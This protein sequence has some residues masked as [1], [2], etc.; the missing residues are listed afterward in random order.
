MDGNGSEKWNAQDMRSEI[1]ALREQVRCQEGRIAALEAELT[2]MR[3]A[4][5]GPGMAPQPAW[6]QV[7][8]GAPQMQPGPQ[9]AW[10]QT[11]PM[12]MP[13]QPFPLAPGMQP[14]WQQPP[15]RK[16]KLSE[17]AVGKYGV[18]VLAS[19]LILLGV[20]TGVQIFWAVIP[21]FVKMLLLVW[22]GA[23]IAVVGY[24]FTIKTGSKNGFWQ[25]VAATGAAIVFIAFAAGALAWNL[26]GPAILGVLLFVW[27]LICVFASGKLHSRVFYVV[28]YIGAVVSMLL[29][30]LQIDK[31]WDVQA[32]AGYGL[33]AVVMPAVGIARQKKEAILPW[34]NYI[35]LNVTAIFC[36]NEIPC[37]DEKNWVGPVVLTA[38]QA[39]SAAAALM[40][41]GLL[42]RG[43]TMWKRVIRAT[44]GF[45]SAY[46]LIAAFIQDC[47][48]YEEPLLPP[49]AG[50]SL[51]LLLMV[52]AAF[53]LFGG[54]RLLSGKTAEERA[55][56]NKEYAPALA[57]PAAWC[58]AYILEEAEYVPHILLSAVMLGALLI[59]IGTREEKEGRLAAY[60]CYL[61]ML[62]YSFEQNYGNDVQLAGTVFL[63]TAAGLVMYAESVI[64]P[65]AFRLLE[66]MLL[67][68]CAPLPLYLLVVEYFE[69][70]E[71][72]DILP[73]AGSILMLLFFKLTKLLPEEAK[74]QA[75]KAET[76]EYGGVPG[77][78]PAD[79]EWIAA[80]VVTHLA[81]V[82]LQVCV[83]MTT[84]TLFGDS[85]PSLVDKTVN[86]ILLLALSSAG[87]CGAVAN[88]SILLAI[89]A[90]LS[91][92]VNLAYIGD[93]LTDGEVTALVV[94]ILGIAAAAALIGIGFAK[95]R[96]N[97]RI[98]GLI[99]MIIYVLKISVFD[100]AESSARG[101]NVLL[102]I[103]GGLVCFAI[104]YTYNRL[105]KKYGER[106]KAGLE[107]APG[108]GNGSFAGVP[109]PGSGE[110]TGTPGPGNNG[111]TGVPGEQQDR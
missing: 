83:Y 82:G 30:I 31:G 7:P 101:M 79:W 72:P 98:L 23:A 76:P 28:S 16:Q 50:G 24:V 18:G 12:G 93:V 4:P 3:Q 111:F 63:L 49:A 36:L 74:N 81:A 6:Q 38:V 44:A 97:L 77:K 25:S 96:K 1:E 10:Q 41:S 95:K 60:I 71:L 58:A 84:F 48:R 91:L 68:L 80:E 65:A 39:L 110:Y 62:V 45:F 85:N 102:L 107:N 109:G 19:I 52:C 26:Y 8:P 34:L 29:A 40:E 35:F 69:A 2:G 94:S 17:T 87:I 56:R 55:F 103:I 42:L 13:N 33:L 46:L 99:T 61:V 88:G 92:N 27:F 100:L 43:E 57:G 78:K 73:L 75:R 37:W 11:P 54:P 14:Q 64:R 108:P 67:A 5:Q 15:K 86:P 20:F 90:V 70:A 105:D 51:S 9:P 104:S 53:V 106:E 22:L 66:P 47:P 21:D 32:V 89:P 59:F